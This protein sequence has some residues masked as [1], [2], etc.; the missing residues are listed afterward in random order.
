MH[1]LRL[2]WMESPFWAMAGADEREKDLRHE[3]VRADGEERGL[4]TRA[5]GGDHDA[6]EQL[7]RRHQRRVFSLI[8][9]LLRQPAQVE[10]I[11]QQVFLKV[12][13]AL[14]RFDF[15]SAFS[16]WLYRIVVNECYDQLRRQRAKKSPP[17]AELTVEE[18]AG[19][20]Q[21]GESATR[22][23]ADDFAT[24]TELRQ[25]LETV[26]RRLPPE[27][28]LV[29]TLKELEGFSVEEI[30]QLMQLQ[31]NTVKVRLFRARR[32]FL[33]AYER[34]VRPKGR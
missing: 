18:L 26:F 5:Q 28:R 14:P 6:F 12:Y 34:V 3:H 24:R 1:A 21:L 22:T 31:E 19:L 25:L 20:E 4:I 10:D 7:L 15:R 30:A 33:A 29:L 8:G 32:R 23:G 27:D 2:T 11:A 9:H 16:T 13:L 17:M